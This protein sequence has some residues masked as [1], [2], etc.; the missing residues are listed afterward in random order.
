ML[1]TRYPMMLNGM[2][3]PEPDR[4]AERQTLS[5]ATANGLLAMLA[6]S[7]VDGSIG[8]PKLTTTSMRVRPKRCRIKNAPVVCFMVAGRAVAER[9]KPP[10]NGIPQGANSDMFTAIIADDEGW[11]ACTFDNEREPDAVYRSDILFLPYAAHL[12]VLHR[13]RCMDR[14]RSHCY[15]Q[16]SRPPTSVVIGGATTTCPHSTVAI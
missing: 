6:P 7:L 5:Q 2:N 10:V 16:R 1:S 4:P 9:L 13:M 14:R 12:A 15:F 3:M 11:S 8:L